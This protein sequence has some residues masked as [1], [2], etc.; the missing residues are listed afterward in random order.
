MKPEQY[1]C[2]LKLAYCG[3]A[4]DWHVSYVTPYVTPYG[5]LSLGLMLDCFYRC[6]MFR[7]ITD[8]AHEPNQP[9][10]Q[11]VNCEMF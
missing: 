1:V 3:I 11:P 9:S 4:F 5:Y 8:S 10:S 6:Q 7:P 2:A